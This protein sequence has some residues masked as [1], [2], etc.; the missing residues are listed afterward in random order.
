MNRRHSI[1]KQMIK[2]ALSRLDHPTALDILEE[3]RRSYP[4]I[5]LGTVYRNLKLLSDDGALKKISFND[6][7]DRFDIGLHPH[8]HIQCIRCGLVLD[9][10]DD[11][12]GELAKRIEKDTNF[13]VSDYNIAFKGI[14]PD[15]NK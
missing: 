13:V 3:I 5:S 4:R 6:S 9:I 2:N 15:C 11:Y 8:H 7:P 14:C 1:Q 12:P 10:N